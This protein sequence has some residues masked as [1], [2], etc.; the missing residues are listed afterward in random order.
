MAQY[1]GMFT[2]SQQ[3]GAIGQSKWPSTTPA[4]TPFSITGS[5]SGLQLL[6]DV[7]D[8]TSYSGTGSTWTDKSGNSR[9]ATVVSTSGYTANVK[10]S[11]VPGMYIS[12]TNQQWQLSG[13]ASTYG[14]TGAH[15]MLAVIYMDSLTG[16]D[17]GI[18]GGNGSNLH[19]Q[20]RSNQYMQGYYGNDIGGFSGTGYPTTTAWQ[21]VWFT[22]DGSSTGQMYI[23]AG[24]SIGSGSQSTF[25]ASTA[26]IYIGSGYSAPS[27]P[28]MGYVNVAAMWNR[29]ISTTE[30]ST[31]YTNNKTRY[32]LT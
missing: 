24:T 11:N 23:N 12:T 30:M 21:F 9:N 3:F 29:K 27:N 25:S 13:T 32:G 4:S 6:L 8:S 15:T 31:I 14:I 20:I 18:F 26:V 7:N 16:G 5:T 28:M 1:S 22:H 19:N 17:Q 2:L 10:S